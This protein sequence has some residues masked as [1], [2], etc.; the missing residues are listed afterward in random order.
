MRRA[1]ASSVELCAAVSKKFK[2]TKRWVKEKREKF[3]LNMKVDDSIFAIILQNPNIYIYNGAF[4][5]H[6]LMHV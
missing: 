4:A 2:K 6:Q 1:C 5:H 3:I